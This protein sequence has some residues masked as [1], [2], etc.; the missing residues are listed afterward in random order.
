MEFQGSGITFGNSSS[1]SGT[2]QRWYEDAEC[3][4]CLQ[5][6]DDGTTWTV[7]ACVTYVEGLPE[8]DGHFDFQGTKYVDWSYR[9]GLS[10]KFDQAQANPTR[11][12]YSHVRR[13]KSF[14]GIPV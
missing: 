10:Y 13:A 1:P 12:S 14:F 9:R 7:E 3:S 2:V 4:V 8:S 11:A 5:S 6:V